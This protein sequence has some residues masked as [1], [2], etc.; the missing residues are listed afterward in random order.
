MAQQDTGLGWSA[1]GEWLTQP[2]GQIARINIGAIT[3]YM[4]LS[5]TIYTSQQAADYL[6]PQGRYFKRYG[7]QVLSYPLLWGTGVAASPPIEAFIYIESAHAYIVYMCNTDPSIPNSYIG[8]SVY[9]D[10]PPTV[11]FTSSIENTWSYNASTGLYYISFEL[12][13]GVGGGGWTIPLYWSLQEGLNAFVMTQIPIF[14]L[15]AGPAVVCAAEWITTEG[16]T[17]IS[18]VL[19]ST[20]ETYTA[21]STDGQAPSDACTTL[22][23]LKD[24]A[25]FYMT[26][27][28]GNENPVDTTFEYADLTQFGAAMPSKVFNL[29]ADPSFSNIIV[30]ESPD[31]YGQETGASTE[32][33]GGGEDMDDDP[34]EE[35]TM[36]VPSVAGHGFCTIY[37]PS[38]QELGQM[39]SYLWS[40]AF[41]VDQVIKL[42]SNPMESILGLSAVPVDLVGTSEQ[43]YLGG[44]ALTGITMPKYTGRTSVKVDF[45][46][47]TVAERW[48]SYL[49]Y[50][51]YTEFSIYLPFIGI[52]SLKA[53]DIMGKT[54]NLTYAID[55]LSGGCVA[56]LRPAGGSVLYEWSGQCAL[57]IPITSR[58]YDNVFQTAM[59]VV[60][61][62]GAAVVAPASAP[63]L[64]GAVASAAVQAAATKPHIE[65]SGSVN[66]ITGFLGQLRPYLIRTIPEAFIPEDQN[67][68]IGYPAYINVDLAAV[69][70]YN[71]VDSIHLEN[72]TATG[73]ELEEIESILKG[74]VIF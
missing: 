22:S 65:R 70:G 38:S 41:D 46:S 49:D 3:T 42:F 48:G 50:A 15:Y 19:I 10:S 20:V 7:T 51:P 57:Q 14:K 21:M 35:E 18:P 28:G 47:V 29:L 34:V 8:L 68:F 32:E 36:P 30:G 62:V 31:P 59:S 54:V 60:G 9:Q 1:K 16:N 2:N 53:D 66:G 33:G 4:P 23:F 61:A 45:G 74:G 52:K 56:Y 63:V 58:N 26:V 13:H 72:V 17:L 44:V 24:G 25:R 55:I 69:K 6:Y 39:S 43:I 27:Y 67:K 71:E 40:G 64:S 5:N 37:V 11:A 12:I 73:A